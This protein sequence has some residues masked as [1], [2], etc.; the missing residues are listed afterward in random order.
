MVS[1]KYTIHSKVGL[2]ARPASM[3]VKTANDY[4]SRVHIRT[5]EMDVDAKSILSVM[6]LGAGC[7]EEIEILVDGPDEEEALQ[8]ILATL[9]GFL[10]KFD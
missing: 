1:A 6:V 3:L 9:D 10:D 2:H 7:G 5:A 8:A 4:D